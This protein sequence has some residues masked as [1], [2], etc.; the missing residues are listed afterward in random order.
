VEESHHLDR[1]QSRRF[2]RD[3]SEIHRAREFVR[4]V[5][6]AWGMD[7][8]SASY[9]LGVSELVTNAV[10][11]GAGPVDV[12]IWVNRDVVHIEVCDEGRGEVGSIRPSTAGAGGIGGWGL[13]IVDRLADE[14]GA[15]R[16]GG[17]TRVWMERRFRGNRRS[18]MS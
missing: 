17:R 2:A 13:R 7:A 18:S 11:H 14:W 6:L 12:A 1:S 9:E 15:S 10:M 4:D 5:L 8:D 3:A 16:D